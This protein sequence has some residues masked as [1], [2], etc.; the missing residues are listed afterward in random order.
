[1]RRRWGV[2][3]IRMVT[4]LVVSNCQ[5]YCSNE[6]RL[7][8]RVDESRWYV[9]LE[10]ILRVM[11][12]WALKRAFS[13]EVHETRYVQIWAY[14]NYV[15]TNLVTDRSTWRRSETFWLA[16]CLP[17][18]DTTPPA[19]G[20]MR[21]VLVLSEGWRFL[22]HEATISAFCLTFYSFSQILF[23]P[24]SGQATNIGAS[25]SPPPKGLFS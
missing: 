4:L 15:Q 5:K 8:A 6:V 21:W 7:S 9:W 25:W 22:L 11:A 3:T 18:S 1:M 19:D 24:Q 16:T 17:E 14:L 13:I 20:S 12:Q 2:S 10:S 23:K